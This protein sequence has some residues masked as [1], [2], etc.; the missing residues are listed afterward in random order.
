MF[1]LAV[2][3]LLYGGLKRATLSHRHS[4]SNVDSA[5]SLSAS[6]TC[7]FSQPSLSLLESLRLLI[8]LDVHNSMAYS[9]VRSNTELFDILHT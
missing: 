7:R 3:C 1:T 4:R 5:P 6:I 9:F 2:G 8:G